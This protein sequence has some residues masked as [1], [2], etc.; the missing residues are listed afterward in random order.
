MS[1]RLLERGGC[2]FILTLPVVPHG[3]ERARHTRAGHT[4]TP[5]KTRAA[6]DEIRTLWQLA[7]SPVVGAEWFSVSITASSVRPKSTRLDYPSKPD[8]DNIAKL[9][10]DALQGHAFPN[11]SRCRSLSVTKRWA[12]EASVV[13]AFSWNEVGGVGH[14]NRTPPGRQRERD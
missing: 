6:T 7:G 13:V 8:V 10:L 4:Y 14:H 12:D 3:Q 2:S 1:S 11:D 9:V 5:A